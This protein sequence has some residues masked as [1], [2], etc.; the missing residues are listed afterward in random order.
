RPIFSLGGTTASADSF[1]VANYGSSLGDEY[2]AW[3]KN[4]AIEHTIKYGA[5]KDDLNMKTCRFNELMVISYPSIEYPKED[6]QEPIKGSL[7]PL[8]SQIIVVRLVD[9]VPHLSVNL[10][11]D[12]ADAPFL[13]FKAYLNND[14]KCIDPK[15]TPEGSR[16]LN[17]VKKSS[18][19]ILLL[20]NTKIQSGEE[21]NYN[22]SLRR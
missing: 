18:E 10:T 6:D 16:T 5:K 9:N 17:N 14:P 20:A 7:K 2:W 21:L 1:F 19:L 3:S 11:V 8:T 22:V 12:D 4:Q 13:K 15:K